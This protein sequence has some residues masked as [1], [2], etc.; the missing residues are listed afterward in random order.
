MMSIKSPDKDFVLCL[1]SE[2]T[3]VFLNTWYTTQGELK[4]YPYNDMI[5]LHHCHTHQTK[6]PVT[7]YGVQE[8]T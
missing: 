6:F 5:S 2:G 4:V 1:Q 7:K 3:V 8:E